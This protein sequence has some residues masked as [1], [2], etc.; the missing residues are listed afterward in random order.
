MAEHGK[1]IRETAAKLQ[2][3][4]TSGIGGL[5]VT[6]KANLGDTLSGIAALREAMKLSPAMEAIRKAQEQTNR[7]EELSGLGHAGTILQNLNKEQENV[8]KALSGRHSNSDSEELRKHE[9][10]RITTPNLNLNVE[11]FIPPRFEETAAGRTAARAAEASEEAAAQLREVAGIIGQMSAHVE[12]LQ[13]TFIVDVLPQ[14]R[15]ELDDGANATNAN[16]QQAK[17]SLWWTKWAVITSIAVT[18]ATTG[19]QLSVA[20][21]YKLEDDEQQKVT[22][23]LLREQLQAARDLNKQLAADSKLLRDEV[24]ALRQSERAMAGKTPARA[25]GSQR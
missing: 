2:E 8:K 23:Q 7:F 13:T 5:S 18:L 22:E 17:D 4:L 9:N 21:M 19:W 24:A 14:W 15:K 25:D 20:R 12:K 3:R 1:R 16:L 6:T 10:N 11:R